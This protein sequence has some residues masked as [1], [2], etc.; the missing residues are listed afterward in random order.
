MKRIFRNITMIAVIALCYSSAEAYSTCTATCKG[1][2]QKVLSSIGCGA[3]GPEF[4]DFRAECRQVLGGTI[5]GAGCTYCGASEVC[6]KNESSTFTVT[7]SGENLMEARKTARASC[8]GENAAP[9][10]GGY[11]CPSNYRSYG[12]D[13]D[14]FKCN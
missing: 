8:M 5:S 13:E 10:T 3:T 4:S 1:Y 6:T 2:S 7:G 11:G 14:S 12:L 9:N